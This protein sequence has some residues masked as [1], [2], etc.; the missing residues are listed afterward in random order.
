M[1]N[2]NLMERDA[3][4]EFQNGVDTFLSNRQYFTEKVLPL[5]VENRDYF[6][7]EGRR[8]LAKGGAEKIAAIYRLVAVFRR[9]AETLDC[10]KDVQ[11]ELVDYIPDL[12]KDGNTAGQGRGSALLSANDNDVNKTI[13]MAQKSAFVDAIIRTCHISD[14]FT[15]DIHEVAAP[16]NKP[17]TVKDMRNLIT[18]KQKSFLESLITEKVAMEEKD[19]WL[20][21]LPQL[22]RIS[23]SEMI[24]SFL[25]A[26]R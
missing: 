13:K 11:G 1:N 18:E 16:T 10:F 20:S 17:L 26:S 2:S 6:V 5:L 9:D 3:I 7:V 15:Q 14:L 8:S 21:V 25:M 12:L 19:K 24:S 22:S 23:A 4:I